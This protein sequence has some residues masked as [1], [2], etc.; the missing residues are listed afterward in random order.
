MF[1]PELLLVLQI[2]HTVLQLN[3]GPWDRPQ[4]SEHRVESM[5]SKM[6]PSHTLLWTSSHRMNRGKS[7]R[8]M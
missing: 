4:T 8:S 6:H 3:E 1:E 5:Q 7:A 2:H